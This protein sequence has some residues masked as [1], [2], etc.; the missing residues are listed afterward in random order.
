[1]TGDYEII[2][3]ARR[4]RMHEQHEQPKEVNMEKKWFMSKTLYANA[5]GIIALFFP[6]FI[7]PELTLKFLAGINIL[8]RWITKEKIVW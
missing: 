2:Q 6:D 3:E 1:M 8:L 4:E 7:S 5:I